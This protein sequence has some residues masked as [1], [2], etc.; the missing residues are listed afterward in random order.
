MLRILI[1]IFITISQY[2]CF[3]QNSIDSVAMSI[4][5]GKKYSEIE[6]IIQEKYH[7]Q[8]DSV[9]YCQRKYGY[10]S[11]IKLFNNKNEK[12][13]LEFHF[14]KMIPQGKVMKERKFF[15]FRNKIIQKSIVKYIRL[16]KEGIEK[17]TWGAENEH[18]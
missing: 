6:E 18:R 16:I 7:F 13:W 3:S 15:D 8:I 4:F 9:G 1:F 14:E 12:S 2:S 17:K 11:G 5:I 10:I